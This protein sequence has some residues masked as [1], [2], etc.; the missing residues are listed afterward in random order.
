M[1]WREK[2]KKQKNKQPTRA[3]EMR[4][5]SGEV[6]V[7]DRVIRLDTIEKEISKTRRKWLT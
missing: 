2:K 6:A 7:L 3:E 5:A 4:R 1:P